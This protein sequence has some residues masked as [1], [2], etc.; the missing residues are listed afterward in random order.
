ML[1]SS[2]G[3]PLPVS[4]QPLALHSLAVT[5]KEVQ[6]DGNEIG[7][8]ITFLN[9]SKVVAQVVFP[10][11][12]LVRVAPCTSIGPKQISPSLI[13]GKP[14]VQFEDDPEKQYPIEFEASHTCDVAHSI[15]MHSI[16]GPL[17]GSRSMLSGNTASWVLN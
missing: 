4:Q 13:T 10:G 11:L 3:F 5:K 14:Y 1:K 8:N 17:L 6:S 2:Y 12:F 16:T 9:V 7:L 15:T